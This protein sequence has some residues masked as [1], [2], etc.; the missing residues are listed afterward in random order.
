MTLFQLKNM[1]TEKIQ[2]SRSE[3]KWKIVLL[4][5]NLEAHYYADNYLKDGSSGFY[6]VFDGHGGLEVVEYITKVLP[7]L[8]LK[9]FHQWNPN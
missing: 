7:E 2:T 5:V 3:D 1:R 9:E 8:F 4:C 6:V